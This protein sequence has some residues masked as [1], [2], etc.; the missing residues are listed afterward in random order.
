M[1]ESML[2]RPWKP[3]ARVLLGVALMGPSYLLDSLLLLPWLVMAVQMEKT[4]P[5]K[6]ACLASLLFVGILPL[7]CLVIGAYLTVAALRRAFQ[8]TSRN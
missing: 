1:P 2:L 7:G 8:V 6:L 5:G 3:V 4:L